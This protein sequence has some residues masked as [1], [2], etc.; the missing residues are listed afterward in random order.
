MRKR[1]QS[2]QFQKGNRLLNKNEYKSVFCDNFRL[3]HPNFL[4][5]CRENQLNH[6][7]LGLVIKKKHV[8]LSVNRN[9]IKRII[10]ESFRHNIDKIKNL[11]VVVISK[12]G[13]NSITN[14]EFRLP[15]EEKWLK[16]KK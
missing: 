5:L 4:I 10:R 15:L 3:T 13:I 6:A 1:L 16:L 12:E 2:S 7:R 14:K 9:K 11:D 8:K